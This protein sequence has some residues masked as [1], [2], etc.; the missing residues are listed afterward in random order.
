MWIKA[1]FWRDMMWIKAHFYDTGDEIHIQTQH[2]A[3]V[4][5]SQ[6]DGESHGRTFIQLTSG[7]NT[8]FQ[9]RETVDEI[10]EQILE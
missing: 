3:A 7:D 8:C 2:I 10:G 9:V 4:Y 1:H 5:S 6:G